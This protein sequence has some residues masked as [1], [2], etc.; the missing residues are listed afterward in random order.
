MLGAYTLGEELVG[1]LGLG[2]KSALKASKDGDTRPGKHSKQL[3]ETLVGSF[4][5]RREEAMARL[6][7]HMAFPLEEAPF[8]DRIILVL[9]ML[10]L[11]CCPDTPKA[12]VINEWVDLCKEYGSE[13]GFRMVNAVLD[14]IEVAA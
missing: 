11:L 8:V 13:D 3:L 2:V 7:S 1:D 5:G 6:D 14:S 4:N 9:A 12:V 10:E